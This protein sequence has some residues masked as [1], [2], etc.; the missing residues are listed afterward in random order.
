MKRRCEMK[1]YD[2]LKAEMKTIQQQVVDA[3][4][5]AFKEVELGFTAGMLK[6]NLASGRGEK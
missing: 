5:T 2:A 1:S 4:R 3:K 6:G